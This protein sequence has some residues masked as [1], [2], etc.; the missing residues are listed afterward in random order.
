MVT[1]IKIAPPEAPNPAPEK[2]KLL[3]F[4]PKLNK[5]TWILAGVAVII[6]A[7]LIIGVSSC[8]RASYYQL[9]LD[10]L[11]EARF[12]M[13]QEEK[14]DKKITVQFFTGMR[15][16][17]Y[18]VN[19]I[20]E[21][22]TAFGVI[23]INTEDAAVLKLPEVKAQMKIGEEA[24]FEIIL[25]KNPFGIGLDFAQDIGR[26]VDASQS[27]VFTMQLPDGSTEVFNL[28]PGMPADSVTWE[29][30]LETATTHMA[31]KLKKAGKFE[32]HVKIVHNVVDGTGSLW[33]VRFTPEHGNSFFCLIDPSG[34]VV[35]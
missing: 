13:K 9:A 20:A 31:E 23:G 12:Y 19:G 8:S 18:G 11:S 4:M 26:L 17:P 2:R 24:P 27:I 5:T 28:Q 15:E 6:V 21:N 7:M 22:T 1:E 25:D 10:N 16:E 29:Q 33:Y 3:N 32:V 30:A 34:K 14:T 35:S